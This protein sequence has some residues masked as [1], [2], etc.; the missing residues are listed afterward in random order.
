MSFRFCRFPLTLLSA[1]ALFAE[2]PA[3]Q[4]NA[5]Y[6]DDQGRTHV[7][8]VVPVPA[9]ISTE[10]QAKLARPPPS[11]LSS[12]APP[13]EQRA[14]M[15]ARQAKD[16]EACLQVYPATVSDAIIGSVPVR[17]VTPPSFGTGKDDCVLLN[18]HGGAFRT[19]AGSLLESIPIAHLAQTKV[20]AVL[21]RLAPEHPFPAAVDDA[22]AVYREL[23][24]TYQPGC[25]G[26]YGTSAG[27]ILT[28]ETA[29]KIKQLGL[30]LPA[31][32]GIFSGWGDFSK[33][34]D[35]LALFGL[36]GLSGSLLP[37][38]PG[39]LLPEYA[40]R[41]EPADPV[42]S[43][44]HADLRGMP[45]ALFLTST[46]DML[47]SGTVILHQAFLRAGNEAQLQVFEALPHAFWL[48]VHLP[49]S[50]AANEIMAKFL[51]HHLGR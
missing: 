27:A 14:R 51:S 38:G 42:L 28:A 26:I 50:R 43:P 7:T 18:L 37:H 40:G 49:E 46:R 11:I 34:G 23:L 44:V 17:I 48:D 45:P 5:S 10:A 15:D 1:S 33:A 31:A 12:G 30:P 25:I 32:P 35:S 36:Q 39:A 24:R 4:P 19:D 3:P 2:V 8:R 22:V 29:V 9:T 6:I 47:L 20:V 16:A 41:T 21:Y 13:A